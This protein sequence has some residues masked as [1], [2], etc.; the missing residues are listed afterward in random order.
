MYRFEHFL[1]QAFE[2][3]KQARDEDTVKFGMSLSTYSG[4][5]NLIVA[6]EDE[7]GYVLH[8]KPTFEEN[9]LLLSK[10]LIA[11]YL[12]KNILNVTTS[13]WYIPI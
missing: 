10:H 7:E 8:I 3:I 12:R 6:K 11:P 1:S 4:I 13:Y 2:G 5:P 9:Y